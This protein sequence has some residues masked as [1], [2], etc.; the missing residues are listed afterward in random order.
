MRRKRKPDKVEM[1]PW[2]NEIHRLP[3]CGRSKASAFWSEYKA[4]TSQ[5]RAKFQQN[6]IDMDQ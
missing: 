4:E 1:G 5:F 3:A 6:N 2:G